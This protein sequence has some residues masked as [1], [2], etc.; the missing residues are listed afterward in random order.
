[1]AAEL[2]FFIRKLELYRQILAETEKQSRL[3]DEN[4]LDGLCASLEARQALMDAVDGQNAAAAGAAAP[5]E[6]RREMA[7]V[8]QSID[9]LDRENRHKVESLAG[10]LSS[11]FREVKAQRSIMAYAQPAGTGARFV[12]K[13]G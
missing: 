10:N 7:G 5:P 8:L 4:D 11:G 3:I 12:D 6:L 1:M 2:G 13:E 9:S